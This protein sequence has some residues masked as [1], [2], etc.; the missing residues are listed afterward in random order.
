M[1]QTKSAIENE[2][3]KAISDMKKQ[4]GELSV[5]IAEKVVKKELSDKEK[6][7]QLID[8]LLNEVTLN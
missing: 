4:M 1:E 5:S 8:Q 7:L 2:K 3:S 6:Q